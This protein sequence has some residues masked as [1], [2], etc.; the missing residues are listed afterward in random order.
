MKHVSLLS[1][2]FLAVVFVF[3]G[4]DKIFH[5][6]GFVNALASYAVVPA[7]VARYLAL[8]VVLSELWVGV[9]L[10]VPRWRRTASLAAAVLLAVFTAALIGNL[11]FSPGSICGC[12]FTITLG[13]ST[14][15]HVVQ[16]LVLLALA[17]SVW[18]DYRAAARRLD[19]PLP[20]GT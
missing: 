4:I 12:W 15:L 13:R 16:N 8:P 14:H 6:D 19:E 17:L 2:I 20:G 5:F 9:G 3:A 11:Y 1:A 7:A 10:L 18:L